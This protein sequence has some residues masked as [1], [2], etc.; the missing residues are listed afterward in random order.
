MK[1]SRRPPRLLTMMLVMPL[2]AGC[3][4][5]GPERAMLGAGEVNPAGANGMIEFSTPAI[6]SAELAKQICPVDGQLPKADAKDADE[7]IAAL[8]CFDTDKEGLKDDAKRRERRNSVQYYIIARSNQ[9][10]ALWI[11]YLERAGAL[12]RGTFNVLSVLAGGAGAIVTGNA[13]RILSGSAGAFSGTGAAID[14]AML[15]GLTEGLVVPRVVLARKAKRA[16]L[17]ANLTK[18]VADYPLAAALADALDYHG[19]CNVSAALAPDTPAATFGNFEAFLRATDSVQKARASLAGATSPTKEMITK[20]AIFFADKVP[21]QV[22]DVTGGNVTF[23]KLTDSSKTPATETIDAF[24][25][26]IKSGVLLS[27]GN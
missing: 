18:S 26:R 15:H 24:A 25:A 23:V 11:T 9:R 13:A 12:N 14:A 1:K 17:D 21:L 20:N 8:T 19:L 27:A 7:I 10:C 3:S 22:T 4:G 6:S 5:I 16:E 2:M